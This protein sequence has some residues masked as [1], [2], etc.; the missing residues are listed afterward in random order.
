MNS[1]YRDRKNIRSDIFYSSCNPNHFAFSY[2]CR[3]F[4]PFRV[5][6]NP[7]LNILSLSFITHSF[8]FVFGCGLDWSI[9]DIFLLNDRPRSYLE[10]EPTHRYRLVGTE[11]ILLLFRIDSWRHVRVFFLCPEEV[12][13]YVKGLLVNFNVLM[14]LQ[15]L[16]FVQTYNI[17]IIIENKIK[18]MKIYLVRQWLFSVKRLGNSFISLYGFGNWL[19]SYCVYTPPHAQWC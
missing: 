8:V 7:N 16:D 18:M 12:F 1:R 19:C 11:M 4:S 6:V 9:Q 2:M 14:R 3:F 15:E 10:L 17:K 5:A 13:D